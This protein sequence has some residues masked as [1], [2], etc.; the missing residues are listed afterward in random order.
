M[1]WNPSVWVWSQ[2]RQGKYNKAIESYLVAVLKSKQHLG[3]FYYRI[4]YC[5]SKLELYKESCEA[6]LVMK[7]SSLFLNKNESIRGKNGTILYQYLLENYPLSLNKW[8]EFANRAEK[9]KVWRVAEYA[10]RE[11]IDR[12]EEFN[13]NIYFGRFSRYRL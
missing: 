12:S 5:L 2:E 9:L 13:L 11:Y 8:L 4:G 3:Y 10:Y 6:F 7:N 1:C